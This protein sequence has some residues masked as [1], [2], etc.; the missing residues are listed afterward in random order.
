MSVRVGIVDYG[1]AGNIRSIEKA[2]KHIGVLTVIVNE[3][4]NFEQ[5]DKLLIPG[6]GSFNDGISELNRSGL[7]EPLKQAIEVKPV[8]GICLGMQLLAKV[9]YEFGVTSGLNVFD[10]AE[11]RKVHCNAPVPHMGFNKVSLLKECSLFDGIADEAFYF[12]HSYEVVDYKNI[13]SLSTYGGHEFVSALVKG[14]VYGVQFH[15]EKSRDAGLE[16]FRNFAKI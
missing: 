8:L 16:L 9:G 6:V 5:V 12:M 10:A 4:K 7:L 15:P 1:V 11:V 13:L 3:A 2:L 14:Q